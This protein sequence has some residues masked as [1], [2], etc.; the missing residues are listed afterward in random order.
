MIEQ[1]FSFSPSQI[2]HLKTLL[3]EGHLPRLSQADI[4]LPIVFQHARYLY[5]SF[6]VQSHYCN[7]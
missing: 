4:C 6:N 3:A 1:D 5:R 2:S 7:G